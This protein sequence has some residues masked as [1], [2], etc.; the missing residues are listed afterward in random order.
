MRNSI[1]KNSAGDPKHRS[2]GGA[3]AKRGQGMAARVDLLGHSAGD[4]HRRRRQTLAQPDPTFSQ[5]VLK[6]IPVVTINRQ[7]AMGW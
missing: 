4:F 3:S 6:P 5:A 1:S 7:T 2:A